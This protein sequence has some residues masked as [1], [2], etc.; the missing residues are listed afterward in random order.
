MASC[1]YCRKEATDPE[2]GPSRWARAVIDNEQVLVCP[3]CQRTNPEWIES[4]DGCPVCGSKRLY[5]A[6]GDRVCRSCGYQWSSE[7]FV[8]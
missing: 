6:L 1:L 4:A 2:K 8:L 5:K 7:E 3:E